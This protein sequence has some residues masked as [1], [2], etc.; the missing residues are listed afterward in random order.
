MQKDHTTFSQRSEIIHWCIL[1]LL[2]ASTSANALVRLQGPEMSSEQGDHKWKMPG[3]NDTYLLYPGKYTC[4]QLS[5]ANQP[6]ESLWALSAFLGWSTEQEQPGSPVGADLR[7]T[8]LSA[9]RCHGLSL[10]L[11]LSIHFWLQA[12]LLLVPSNI[13]ALLYHSHD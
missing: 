13:P 6:A 9:Q 2:P 5:L 3:T 11:G 8:Q 10:W 12:K 4:P 7:R 1:Y